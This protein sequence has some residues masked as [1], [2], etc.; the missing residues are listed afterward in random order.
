MPS[1]VLLGRSVGGLSGRK[2]TFRPQ[3]FWQEVL[4]EHAVA[5]NL[6]FECDFE[7]GKNFARQPPSDP[8][9]TIPADGTYAL[10]VARCVSDDKVPSPADAA[11]ATRALREA[12][13]VADEDTVLRHLL[14]SCY[15]PRSALGPALSECASRDNAAGV[16]LLLAA[17]ADPRAPS[18]GK[19]ALHVACER[20][21]EN[22]ARALITAACDTVR[23]LSLDGRTPLQAAR[24]CDHGPL[25]R[26]LE[27][28][29]GGGPQS[30]PT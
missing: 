2:L 1:S 13:A 7:S 24:E 20:G 11:L 29:A 25:A 14:S 9:E 10:S 4:P 22:A 17:G 16:A 18:D 30:Q 28:L 3:L 12:A 26:R 8:D 5:A 6:Q 27:A 21:C 23:V 15:C 19:T